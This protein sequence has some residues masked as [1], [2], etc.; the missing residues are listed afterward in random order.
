MV[1][2]T[3]QLLAPHD[4]HVVAGAGLSAREAEFQAV[5]RALT[6][7]PQDLTLYVVCTSQ[8]QIDLHIR[9]HAWAMDNWRQRDGTPILGTD[10]LVALNEHL[11]GTATQVCWRPWGTSSINRRYQELQELLQVGLRLARPPDPLSP[12]SDRL[13]NGRL[14][15]TLR[16]ARR[17]GKEW[18]LCRRSL[19]CTL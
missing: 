8:C 7:V 9:L 10:T 4:F 13:C 17:S 16:I 11:E 12:R 15:G 5:L 1:V 14:V 3:E 19:R 6:I 2:P 18:R